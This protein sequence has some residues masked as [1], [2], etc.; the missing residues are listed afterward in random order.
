VCE[1]ERSGLLV[2]E[3]FRVGGGAEGQR[4]STYLVDA[5]LVE[6]AKATRAVSARESLKGL[7]AG[8]ARTESGGSVERVKISWAEAERR[9]SERAA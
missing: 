7:N 5:A 4:T 2:V 3:T 8:S 1:L 6:Q 9:L